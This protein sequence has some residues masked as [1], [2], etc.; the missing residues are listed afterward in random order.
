[1]QAMQIGGLRPVPARLA[2]FYDVGGNYTG[3][4]LAELRPIDPLNFTPSDLFAT[5]LMSVRI[6]PG[7]TRRILQDGTTRSILLRKLRK[8][9]DVKLAF[10]GC[11]ELLAMADLYEEV[12][13]ALSAAT[14][15]R[16]DAW[17]TAS[18]LCAR[19]RSELFPVRDRDVRDHLGLSGLRNYQVDWQIFRELLRDD[20]ILMTIDEMVEATYATAVGRQLQLD[21]SRL[22]LLDAAIWTFVNP[23]S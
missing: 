18:K 15:K 6:G 16:P 1:M 2:R 23:P 9:P 3:A 12:K 21:H 13:R 22:R 8:V 5:T 14:V 20:E 11:S 4:S 19:K 17:V 7:A 10:A